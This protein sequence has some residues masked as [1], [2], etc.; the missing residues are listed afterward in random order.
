M[1]LVVNLHLIVWPFHGFYV[2]KIKDCNIYN[3]PLWIH[4]SIT[5]TQQHPETHV[6]NLQITVSTKLEVWNI[7]NSHST[8]QLD[9]FSLGET[10]V[11]MVFVVADLL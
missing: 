4:Y 3:I 11:P 8:H 1:L 9:D 7:R 10:V 6:N 5:I 2:A